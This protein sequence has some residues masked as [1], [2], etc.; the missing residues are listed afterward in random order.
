MKDEHLN[1]KSAVE[2]LNTCCVELLKGE[3]ARQSTTYSFRFLG[4][5]G[6]LVW[7]EQMDFDAEKSVVHPTSP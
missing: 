1:F 3:K 5:G 7:S 6:N 4:G 2:S